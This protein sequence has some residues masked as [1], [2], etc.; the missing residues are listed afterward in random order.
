MSNLNDFTPV[1]DK[2]S[3]GS[4]YTP[5]FQ[6]TGTFP[7]NEGYANI[8]VLNIDGDIVKVQNTLASGSVRLTLPESGSYNGQRV[9]IICLEPTQNASAQVSVW[10]RNAVGG[11]PTINVNYTNATFS[12]PMNIQE[13]MWAEGR[14]WNTN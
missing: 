12:F 7:Y 14:W 6:G 5:T 8:P 4:S 10:Y 2:L 1:N 3:V 11:T 13:F 9:K